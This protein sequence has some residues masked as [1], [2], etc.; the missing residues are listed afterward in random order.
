MQL[1]FYFFINIKRQSL[2]PSSKQRWINVNETEPFEAIS[3]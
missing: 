2:A 1:A 3:I